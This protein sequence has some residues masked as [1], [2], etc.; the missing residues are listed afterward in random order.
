MIKPPKS[1][2][3]MPLLIAITVLAIASSCIAQSNNDQI[4]PEAITKQ[5]K[6]TALNINNALRKA[7]KVA[8]PSVV[9][10]HV[11][12]YI[13]EDQL[14][15][16]PE[17]DT[18]TRNIG[19]GCIISQDGYIITNHHVIENA[20]R[21]EVVLSD[22]RRFDAI[23][24]M[25]DPETDLAIVM[26]EPDDK[27]LPCAHFGDS[28]NA[29]VGDC[30]LAIGNPFEL[31]QTVTFGI[32]SYKGRK[33]NMTDRWSYEDFIQ[34]DALTNQGSSGGPLVDLFGNIIGINSKV[35]A[36]SG[37]SA[38]Y[39]FAIP[40]NLVKFVSDQLI[41]YK[42]VRRGY[43]GIKELEPQS[44]AIMRKWNRLQFEISGKTDLYNF[45]QILDQDIDGVIVNRIEPGSPAHR[46]NIRPM[47][48][49]MEI[50]GQK[51]LSP[52]TLLRILAETGPNALI[53]CTIWRINQKI[54]VT[55]KLADRTI[56]KYKINGNANGERPPKRPSKIGMSID[57]L[58]PH[59]AIRYGYDCATNGIVVRKIYRN[60][61]ADKCGL[62]V[63][64]I[65]ISADST[66]LPGTKAG[67][68]ELTKI[69]SNADLKKGIYLTIKD[70][71]LPLKVIK[72]YESVSGIK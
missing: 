65:I 50:N 48:I 45:I 37:V 11:F 6:V 31:H 36:K 41:K 35:Y 38:G 15:P 5:E 17:S 53:E 60:S 66:Y 23:E 28:D 33:P 47:D 3:L 59:D 70:K 16:E 58:Q 51:I 10:I 39:G 34:T 2:L 30:V 40:S 62:S 71:Q 49:I 4:K 64:D 67:I 32:I 13:P 14:P 56:A 54:T 27:E 7:V 18:E 19:S 21:I 26:I 8:K 52:D 29:Q 9:F 25:S 69:I 63:G 55:I 44:I 72:L 43:I 24:T 68:R 57:I 46:A 20:D 61:I 22:G 12:R 1:Y 42:E